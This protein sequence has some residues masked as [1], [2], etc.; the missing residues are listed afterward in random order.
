MMPSFTCG[1]TQKTQLWPFLKGVFWFITS[2]NKSTTAV[3]FVHL[4]KVWIRTKLPFPGKQA[5]G[6]DESSQIS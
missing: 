1:A 6:K 4:F 3:S 5:A 2:L